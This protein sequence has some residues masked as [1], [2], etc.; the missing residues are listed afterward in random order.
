[1]NAL[2]LRCRHGNEPQ[3][4]SKPPVL[5]HRANRPWFQSNVKEAEKGKFTES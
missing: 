2:R 1:L 3:N 4:Q 5:P